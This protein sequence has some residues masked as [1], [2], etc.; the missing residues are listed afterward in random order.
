MHDPAN[1]ERRIAAIFSADVAGYSR[2]IAEDEVATLQ[3][4]TAA[5]ELI[6]GRRRLLFRVRSRSAASADQR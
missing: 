1:I 3:R 5:R 4:L 6:S 2:R